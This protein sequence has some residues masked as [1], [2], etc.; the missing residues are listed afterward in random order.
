MLG[1]IAF[2]RNYTC[3]GVNILQNSP[4]KIGEK[5]T[6]NVRDWGR[7]CQLEG[8][9]FVSRIV[10]G[11]VSIYHQGKVITDFVKY[12]PLIFNLLNRLF[13]SQGIIQ[14]RF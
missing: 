10:L 14:Y 2:L 13:S 3:T 5:F 12:S 8:I 11:K 9:C 7:V 1:Y 6:Q 4:I